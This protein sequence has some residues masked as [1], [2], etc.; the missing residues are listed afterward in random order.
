MSLVGLQCAGILEWNYNIYGQMTSF[1]LPFKVWKV[2]FTKL[3]EEC[4]KDKMKPEGS[5]Y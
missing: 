1:K 4:Q 5:Y 2:T 3:I